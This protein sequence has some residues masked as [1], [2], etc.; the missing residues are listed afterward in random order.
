[1]VWENFVWEL[2]VDERDRDVTENWFEKVN[3]STDWKDLFYTWVNGV[4][5]QV[6]SDL[7]VFGV[8]EA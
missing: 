8:G 7:K 6:G 4:S 5:I 1:M 3:L 2:I